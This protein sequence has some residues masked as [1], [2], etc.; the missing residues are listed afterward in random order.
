[1][2]DVV[3][4]IR[5]LRKSPSFALTAIAA[6]LAAVGLYGVVSTTVRQRTSEI[7]VRMAFGAS[8]G[9]ILRMVLSLGLRLTIVGIGFG[10]AIAVG[11][12]RLMQSMLTGVKPTDPA[13][14]VTIALVFLIVA[15]VACALPARR[16][17]RLSPISALRDE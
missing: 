10:L 6:I 12:T 5:S 8:A 7:G 15:S 17:A 3:H 4:A 1:M 16:A 13:T 2:T 9:S 11:T 14:F